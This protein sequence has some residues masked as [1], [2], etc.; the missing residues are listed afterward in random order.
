MLFQSDGTSVA[1]IEDNRVHLQKVTV[2]RDFGTEMEI[3]DGLTGNEQ[4]VTNPG[5][6]LVEGVEVQIATSNTPPKNS[7]AAR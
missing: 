6:R 4:I 2:G 5:A 7:T 3:T 1:V